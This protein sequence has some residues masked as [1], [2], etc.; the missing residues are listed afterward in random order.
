MT[1]M[2]SAFHGRCVEDEGENEYEYG[3]EDQITRLSQ[4]NHLVDRHSCVTRLSER[5]LHL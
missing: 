4:P 1:E 3:L 5:M 2:V